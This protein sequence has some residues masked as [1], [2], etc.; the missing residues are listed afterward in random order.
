MEVRLEQGRTWKRLLGGSGE[1]ALCPEGR[2]EH[3]KRLIQR[4]DG[5][6]GILGRSSG[7]RVQEVG[8]GKTC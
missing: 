8:G 6:N 7:T 5:Q 1:S 2:E 4:R 3:S